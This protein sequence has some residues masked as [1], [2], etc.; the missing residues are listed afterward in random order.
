MTVVC[1]HFAD[2][3]CTARWAELQQRGQTNF[4]YRM[5]YRDIL[6]IM[7]QFYTALTAVCLFFNKELFDW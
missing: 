4:M 3:I 7:H 1:L 5:L 2:Q 6:P